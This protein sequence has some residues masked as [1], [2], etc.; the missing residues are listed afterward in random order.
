MIIIE[1][2]NSVIKF[3]TTLSHEQLSEFQ[4]EIDGISAARSGVNLD[5]MITHWVAIQSALKLISNQCK[6]D[7]HV[8]REIYA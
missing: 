2:Y 3:A 8:F 4:Q 7:G 6:A 5:G 1:K